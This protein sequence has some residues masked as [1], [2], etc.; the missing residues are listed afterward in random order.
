MVVVHGVVEAL[1]LHHPHPPPKVASACTDAGS[2][3]THV[4]S[5]APMAATR[6]L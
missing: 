1:R 6:L 3:M 5:T 2:Q 4:S